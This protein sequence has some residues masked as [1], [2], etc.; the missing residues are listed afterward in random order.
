[1]V[2]RNLKFLICLLIL[3]ES[4]VAQAKCFRTVS[5]LKANNVRTRWQETTHNDRKPLTIS[6]MTE[7]TDL[8]TQPKRPVYSG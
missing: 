6:I 3:S 8:S 7:P 1:M 2:L 5:E 4:T